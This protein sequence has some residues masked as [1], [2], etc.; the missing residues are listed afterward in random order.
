MEIALLRP[1]AIRDAPLV[2]AYWLG[3]AGAD[4]RDNGFAKI[5][6]FHSTPSRRA[7]ELERQLRYLKRN[8][9]VVPLDEVVRVTAE[10]GAH[11]GRRLALTFDDGLRNNARVIY[12]ILKKLGL[13]ATFFVT[14]GLIDRKATVWSLEMRMRLKYLRPG[15]VDALARE[16]GAPAAAGNLVEWMKTLR[17]DERQRVE[18]RVRRASAGFVPSAEQRE[19]TELASWDELRSLDPAIV[20]IG[21][22]TLTHPILSRSPSE[23]VEPEVA[24]SRRVLEQQLQRTVDF[25]AYPNGDENEFVRDCVR[26]HYRAAVTTIEHWVRPGSDPFRLPRVNAPLGTLRLCWNMHLPVYLPA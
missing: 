21:S 24:E 11:A 8:F 5:L 25:F 1:S 14:P 26:R 13:P 23:Q 9:D 16:F 7:G 10:G 22:H 15:I 19:S 4:R 6:T 12:P 20:T 2:F 3:L 17:T 18:D